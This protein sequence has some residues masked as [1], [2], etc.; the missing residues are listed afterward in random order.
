CETRSPVVS[1]VLSSRRR[2]TSSKRHWSSDVCSSDLRKT[3]V[4]RGRLIRVTRCENPLLGRWCH[5]IRFCSLCSCAHS[6]HPMQATQSL[7]IGRA[8][9][10]ERVEIR[11]G[12]CAVHT[13]QTNNARRGT[14]Q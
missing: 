4:F 9:C 3:V 14:L 1:F 12:G 7:E 6:F 11:A 5:S 10:R 13:K 2:H 8:S